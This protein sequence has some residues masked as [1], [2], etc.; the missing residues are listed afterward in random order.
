MRLRIIVL[1][2]LCLNGAG[3]SFSV[4]QEILPTGIT[5][6]DEEKIRQAMTEEAL[7]RIL[8]K[9]ESVLRNKGLGGD[10][11]SDQAFEK[12]KKHLPD[13]VG[14]D[15]RLAFMRQMLQSPP[16]DRDIEE[17]QTLVG[18]FILG[19]TLEIGITMQ[20]EYDQAQQVKEKT[21]KLLD[22]LEK[23][24]RQ[25]EE[26]L[27]RALFQV[28]LTEKELKR[29]RASDRRWKNS[30]AAASPFKEFNNLKRNITGHAP[31]QDQWLVFELAEKYRCQFPFLDEFLENYRRLAK[32][33]R[34]TAR[35]VNDLLAISRE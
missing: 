29:I 20:D 31:D 4:A 12:I 13:G 17:F 21:E 30:A 26:D 25:D 24:S 32:D 16:P 27:G 5:C 6:C 28:D 19:M 33:F 3:L 1:F 34:E 18:H 23:F 8:A 15:Q 11:L 22:R 10:Y 14:T 9:T 7:A 2:F 35:R